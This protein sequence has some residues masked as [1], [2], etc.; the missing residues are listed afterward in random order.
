[1]D[2]ERTEYT[3]KKKKDLQTVNKH[4]KRSLVIMEMQTKT[5]TR[6][7]PHPLRELV[8]ES[9]ITVSIGKTVEKS[10]S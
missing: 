6:Y 9:Y 2:K 10:E 7:I 3:L 8:S 5:T 4:M 1:M